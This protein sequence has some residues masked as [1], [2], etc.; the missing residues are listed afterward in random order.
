MGNASSLARPG[1]PFKRF[2]AF[3]A[4]HFRMNSRVVAADVRRRMLAH[5][6]RPPRHRGGYASG[7][8][9]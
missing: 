5:K 3:N 2:F 1:A 6:K 7:D 8:D 9:A 4:P